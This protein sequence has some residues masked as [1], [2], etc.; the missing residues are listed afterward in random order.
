[1]DSMMRELSE[2]LPTVKEVLID[3]RDRFLAAKIWECKAGDGNTAQKITAV[4]GA[5][6]LPGVQAHLEKIACGEEN[7]DTQQISFVPKKTLC[8]KI[9]GWI[10][11]VL[12]VAL[13]VAGFYFGGKRLGTKMLGSWVAWNSILAA[14]G[15]ILAAG[16]PVTVLV[17]FVGAPFT[18]LCPFI[19][20]GFLTGIVQAFVK[21][22]KVK[23]VET[24]SDDA[25]S[26]KG[27][28]SNR[29]T[30]VLLVFLL[31]SVGSS[32]GTFVAGASIVKS[33]TATVMRLFGK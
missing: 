10:I 25:T 20:I 4:L 32:I 18:S 22:P 28:Y 12:I 2:F 24:L 31:S 21:K 29:I 3:E 5:G 17:A 26:L 15:T 33:L 27:F 19:G 23:D 11:P 14:A 16:H 9:A 7:T 8:A 1:M 13:I 6:H 30:R